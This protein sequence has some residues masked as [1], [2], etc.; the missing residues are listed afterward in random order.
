MILIIILL[1]LLLYLYLK[2]DKK[3]KKN[4]KYKLLGE[5]KRGIVGSIH[6]EIRTVDN[7]EDED[8][9]IIAKWDIGNDG[10]NKYI[11]SNRTRGTNRG[12]N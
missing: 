4:E 6:G 3:E 12:N 2:I 1:I 10:R 7:S 9:S 11:R 8:G 5:L